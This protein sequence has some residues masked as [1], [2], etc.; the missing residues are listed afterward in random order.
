MQCR[1]DRREEGDMV[2]A[3]SGGEGSRPKR[4]VRKGVV[5]RGK[6]LGY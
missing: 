4:G 5:G 2:P 6:G 3:C 1:E